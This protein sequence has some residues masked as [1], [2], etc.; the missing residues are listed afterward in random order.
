[1]RP[2]LLTRFKKYV[3]GGPRFDYTAASPEPGQQTATGWVGP[4]FNISDKRWPQPL[5]PA[6]SLAVSTSK[7]FRYGE[8]GLGEVIETLRLP[9]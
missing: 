8:M 5:R 9:D 1:M 6:D 3:T 7:G 2:G 4:T